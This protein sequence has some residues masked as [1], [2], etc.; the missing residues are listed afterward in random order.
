MV[1]AVRNY[2]CGGEQHGRANDLVSDHRVLHAGRLQPPQLARAAGLRPEEQRT[3]VR[4]P[5]R[6]TFRTYISHILATTA[7]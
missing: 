5:Q 4:G 1:F 7:A 2:P 6:G 3:P